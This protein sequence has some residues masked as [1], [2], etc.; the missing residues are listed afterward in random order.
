MEKDLRGLDA[1]E[2]GRSHAIEMKYLAEQRGNKLEQEL[3]ILRQAYQNQKEK[4]EICEKELRNAKNEI[5]S[6]K[7]SAD[8]FKRE[9]T[10]LKAE[11]VAA[12]SIISNLRLETTNYD[13]RVNDI[14]RV[15]NNRSHEIELL[16][17]EREETEDVIKILRNQMEELQR[18]RDI[19]YSMNEHD[20]GSCSC[21]CCDHSSNSQTSS[22]HVQQLRKRIQELNELYDE[23]E[24]KRQVCE[25]ELSNSMQV[26]QD[27]YEEISRL[28]SEHDIMSQMNHNLQMQFVELQQKYMNMKDLNS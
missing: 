2:A 23:S 16:L 27:L 17:K 3:S 11:I 9:N 10:V 8:I 6:W 12:N 25:D 26:Q 1:A 7:E 28:T 14:Q 4:Y 13:Q 22:V 20:I 5:I 18:E 24:G 15:V 19:T 21:N